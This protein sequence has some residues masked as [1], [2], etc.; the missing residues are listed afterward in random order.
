[1]P[2]WPTPVVVLLEKTVVV[3]QLALALQSFFAAPK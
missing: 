3:V 1:M 2:M